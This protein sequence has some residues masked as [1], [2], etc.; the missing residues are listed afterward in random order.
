M[1]QTKGEVWEKKQAEHD[2]EMRP[3]GISRVAQ[4]KN[5]VWHREHPQVRD[6]TIRRMLRTTVC[7]IADVCRGTSHIEASE[8]PEMKA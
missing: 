7:D 3:R 6:E 1:G 2:D 5:P 8:D 4:S